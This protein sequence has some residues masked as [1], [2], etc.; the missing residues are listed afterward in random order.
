ML[1]YHPL[2]MRYSVQ[3][4][5]PKHFMCVYHC[6]VVSKASL[7]AFTRGFFSQTF[8]DVH[9]LAASIVTSLDVKL[10]FA[11]SM[12]LLL[13]EHR[14]RFHS[15]PNNA[16]WQK[17]VWASSRIK[18]FLRFSG[19]TPTANM[20][21]TS[22]D[23]LQLQN[24]NHYGTG[25]YFKKIV[26]NTFEVRCFFLSFNVMDQITSILFNGFCCAFMLFIVYKLQKLW[27]MN[28]DNGQRYME[29]EIL[30]QHGSSSLYGR[31]VELWKNSTKLLLCIS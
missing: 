18:L 31:G 17:E 20:M 9:Y 2:L 15:K 6:F 10:Q 7:C 27:Q 5:T 12:E 30:N 23:R 29:Q 28:N 11:A 26:V 22:Q 19:K 13:Q 3:Y 21:Y 14:F 1:P 8:P 24:I 25:V 16:R 4:M